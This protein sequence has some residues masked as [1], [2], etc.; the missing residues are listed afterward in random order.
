MSKQKVFL[1]VVVSTTA[2]AGSALADLTPNTQ[3]YAERNPSAA[4]G[5]SGNATLAVRT[6]LGK[7]GN[8]VVDV[9][10]G[11]IGSDTPTGNITKLQFKAF[12]AREEDAWVHNFSGLTGATHQKTFGGFLR[13][14]PLQTHA[15]I[16]G[17]DG[18]RTDVVVTSSNIKVRPDLK[19][20]DIGAPASEKTGVAVVIS[21]VV[22]ELN[23]DLGAKADCVLAVN[24]VEADRAAGIWVDANGTVSCAFTK[25]FDEVGTYKLSV[26]ATNVDPGDW[27]TENNTATGSIEIVS[28]VVNAPFQ[29][30][31]QA[32]NFSSQS[33]GRRHGW[34][35]DSY[36]YGSYHSDWDYSWNQ[37]Y[38]HEMFYV[39]G[40]SP[41]FAT[42]PLT[43][44]FSA[45]ADGASFV[46]YTKTLEADFTQSNATFQQ[47]RYHRY[48]A[49]SG[50][51][52]YVNTY[53]YSNGYAQTSVHA[54]RFGGDVVYYS[55]GY[56]QVWYYY[57]GEHYFYDQNYTSAYQEGSFW[58]MTETASFELAITDSNNTAWSAA[59]TVAL[60]PYSNQ[61]SNP[62]QCYSWNDWYW[63]GSYGYQCYED[64][65]SEQGYR[66]FANGSN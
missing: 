60:A 14:Q 61:S 4:T 46:D 47:S 54:R 64:S 13:G 19:V 42:F 24:D 35:N 36:Y 2:L 8:T 44:A 66:G 26:S 43:V 22:S 37:T 56:S 45:T 28:P 9:T 7:D 1:A 3:R 49:A 50:H 27:D 33:S 38:R 52:L 32:R 29:W 11:R 39:D 30:H 16:K 63:Y 20:A 41:T 58:P 17:I 21:A 65:Y 23:G 55:Q 12:N 62:W 53:G 5:R 59:G 31:A 15:N 34:Y 10:A 48:D 6:L 57:S 18:K 40:Y 25:T 51:Y